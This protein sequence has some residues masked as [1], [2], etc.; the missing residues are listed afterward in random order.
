MNTTERDR[1]AH[2]LKST[3]MTWEAVAMQ[4]HYA[5][6]SVA[7][8]AA[9]RHQPNGTITTPTATPIEAVLAMLDTVKQ[10][11][12][13]PKPR[14]TIDGDIEVGAALYHRTYPKAVFK[15]V[16]WN[17]DG[18]AQVWGGESQRH[19][20]HDFRRGDIS[21]APT[22]PCEAIGAWAE[23]HLFETVTVPE[24]AERFG[25]RVPA[26]R[27][28]IQD[29]PDRFRRLGAGRYETRDP[30]ADRQLDRQSA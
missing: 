18:S 13:I 29:R 4:M 6:G 2:T 16:K 15:F 1:E 23:Q 27:D 8:R 25:A 14:T 7:R 26:V 9:M 24:L 30:A 21:L 12:S 3:G 20:Y 11:P 28:Y 19:M 22:E 10:T 17:V 5:N